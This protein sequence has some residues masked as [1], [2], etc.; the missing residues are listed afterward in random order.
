MKKLVSLVM[1]AAV[2]SIGTGCGN[3]VEVPPAHIGK[4]MSKT[5][6]EKGIK[7][8]S[9]FRLPYD[10]WN[11]PKLVLT[12]ASDNALSE[13]AL[14]VYMPK[15]KLNLTVDIRGTYTISSAEKN[16]DKIF[17]K[18][19][20][21]DGR[22]RFTMIVTA[23]RVYDTYAKQV[24]RESART[25]LTQYEISYVMENRDAVSTE[26]FSR[27]TEK[28]KDSPIKIN[29]LGFADIQPPTVIVA[30]QIAAKERE[31][32]IQKAE[33][34]KQI[35]L[36]QADAALAVAKKQQEVDLIEAETQVLVN[37]KLAEGVTQAFVTQRGLRILEG[38]AKSDNK[39]FFM[40]QEVFSNPALL[41]PSLQDA[42]EGGSVDKNNTTAKEINDIIR[43]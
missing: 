10:A 27:I 18:I 43:H 16:V 9:A 32:E 5:G 42:Y 11:P 39:V 7:F 25:I 30:A 31:V 28:L 1:V 13:A 4:I 24:I 21:R 22:N 34:Q 17:A 3:R 14:Q 35:D 15:D 33:A 8:P 20:P 2:I 26:L 6:F 36:A 29:R 41:I 19:T 37:Q 12:E 23:G 40:P 38:M